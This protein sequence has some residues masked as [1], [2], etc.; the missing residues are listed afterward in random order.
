MILRRLCIMYQFNC[1]LLLVDG[2]WRPYFLCRFGLSKMI[3]SELPFHYLI[4]FQH[5]A[6]VL[7]GLTPGQDSLNQVFTQI[8]N[9]YLLTPN[10]YHLN[11]VSSDEN[12]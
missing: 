6:P 10:F 11:K 2:E 3:I 8:K 12:I 5:A 9:L 4:N 7:E 1:H